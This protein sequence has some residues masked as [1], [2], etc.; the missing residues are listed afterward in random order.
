MT[1]TPL[2]Q[3]DLLERSINQHPSLLATLCAIALLTGC[4]GSTPTDDDTA[5][6]DDT[7]DD[8][9]T[10]AP[11]PT[12]CPDP[13]PPFDLMEPILVVGSG[14]A[15][16][17]TPQALA[18]A[19]DQVNASGG[20]SITFA[21]GDAPLQI[22][23]DEALWVEAPLMLDGEHNITLSGG[24]SSRILD[25]DHYVDLTVQRMTFSDAVAVDY[26][27][28]IHLP[29]YG[30]LRV[31]DCTFDGN[32]CTSPGA[33]IG[34]AAFYAGG[35]DEVIV[36]GSTF[37]DNRASN[38][39][40]IAINGSNMVIVHSLFLDN[41]AFGTGASSGD[42]GLGGAVYID[43]MNREI[44]PWPFVMCGVE[45]ADNRA[46]AHGSALFGYFYEGTESTTLSECLFEGN[47][48]D[49]GDTGSGTVYHQGAALYV[50]RCTFA[51]NRTDLHAGVFHLATDSPTEIVNSTFVGNTVP[52]VGAA[53]FASYAPVV[54]RSST[55]AN[56]HADY[57]PVIYTEDGSNIEL[58]GTILAHNVA[59]G[60]Y[61]G[62]ACA[63]TLSGGSD[64]I[65]WPAQRPNGTD[66]TPC[67]EGITFADPLL[68][69][70]ADNGG[71][72]PTMALLPG[73]PAIDTGDSCPDTDQRGE[74]RDGPCD[75]GAYEV[76]P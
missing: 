20:G 69:P 64:N 3:Q 36:S 17:C 29:W 14:T 68:D 46:R 24:G 48:V 19:V 47:Y 27:A 33:D 66:D 44:P 60:E 7:G 38:G 8:D 37:V 21:C 6:D 2:R 34:G 75:V 1:T 70:L 41:E 76:Q 56:H 5:T 42:G 58:Y 45:L 71:P 9:D 67:V 63:M 49:G 31:V 32:Q 74:P 73:S 61:N 25:C 30:T 12:E 28:A 11:Y 51:N 18:D 22:T 65:Q 55:F 4:P 57:G 62:Q 15:S 26:G 43:G 39:G 13:Y 59:D 72:N 10:T 23:V 40:A 50:S 54:I 52:E 35:M 16:S 53:V